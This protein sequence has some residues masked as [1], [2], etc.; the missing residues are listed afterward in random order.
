MVNELWT[1]Q[2]NFISAGAN[3]R[4]ASADVVAKAPIRPGVT[5]ATAGDL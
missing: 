3:W 4:C 5:P 1:E 2:G